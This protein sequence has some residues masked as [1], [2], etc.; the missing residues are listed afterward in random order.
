M[1]QIGGRYCLLSCPLSLFRKVL[2]LVHLQHADFCLFICSSPAGNDSFTD[3]SISVPGIKENY[4]FN[5][6]NKTGGILE[7][8]FAG[9]CFD[10]LCFLIIR[11]LIHVFSWKK[12]R[13]FSAGYS[14]PLHG[15]NTTQQNGEVLPV[16]FTLTLAVIRGTKWL[17]SNFMDSEAVA[18]SII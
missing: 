5:L 3:F 6:W 2:E 15:A 14:L 11:D 7:T 10:L 4:N 8:F 9:F 16:S 17:H 13:N 1:T 12:L 18:G